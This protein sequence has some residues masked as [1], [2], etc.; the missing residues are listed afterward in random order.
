MQQVCQAA[1][2]M[3]LV[4]RNLCLLKALRNLP[5]RCQR[6]DTSEKLYKNL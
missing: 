3:G 1:R 2:N 5:S 4:T 6:I